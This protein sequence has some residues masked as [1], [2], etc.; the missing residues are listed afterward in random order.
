MQANAVHRPARRAWLV[1]IAFGHLAV[2][3]AWRPVARQAQ[4]LAGQPEG[5]LI[6]LKLPQAI[7]H[8]SAELPPR[9]PRVQPT[10]QHTA[11]VQA[12]PAPPPVA[13]EA[14]SPDALPASAE[15][16][17]QSITLPAPASLP[18]DPFAKP[19]V[20]DES[21]L[22]KTRKSAASIDR[23]LRKESLN[24]YATVVDEDKAATLSITGAPPPKPFAP[25]SFAGANGIVHK[26]YMLRG[27]MV[28][29]EVDH[30]GTGGHDVFRKGSKARLV[31]CPK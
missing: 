13:S 17:P 24:K 23:Q 3:M 10:A 8:R 14:V 26:R 6:L 5:E 27:K 28:C 29:E 30:I 18:A 4:E 15:A 2:L 1:L 16:M 22:E 9:P 7:R 12:R 31:K 25:E 11:A 21:L 20:R 19:A